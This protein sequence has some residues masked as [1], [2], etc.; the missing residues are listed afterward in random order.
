MSCIL[1]C[2]SY[3][4]TYSITYAAKAKTQQFIR[5]KSNLVKKTDQL[6]WLCYAD[7]VLIIDTK[8]ELTFFWIELESDQIHLLTL[9]ILIK[10]CWIVDSATTSIIE[11]RMISVSWISQT[12]TII[13][14]TLSNLYEVR[15]Y[16][17][18]KQT[19]ALNDLLPLYI[20]FEVINRVLLPRCLVDQICMRKDWMSKQSEWK[21]KILWRGLQDSMNSKWKCEWVR[22]WLIR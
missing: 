8:D 11:I 7:L 3:L 4:K 21:R 17:T 6:T 22:Q 1:S 16:L 5:R 10:H 18:T 19:S 15:Q 13:W 12:S 20:T 9:T 14:I 2:L